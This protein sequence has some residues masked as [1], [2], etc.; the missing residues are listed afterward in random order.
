MEA[1]ELDWTTGTV[2]ANVRSGSASPAAAFVLLHAYAH[3]GAASVR[4]VLEPLLTHAL[5]AAA[6]APDAATRLEWLG[7]VNTAATF[8]DDDRLAA[9]VQE[10]LAD[11]IDGLERA[12]AA[13]YEPGEAPD[14]RSRSTHIV[15]ADALLTAFDLTGR[16]PYPML[17]EELLQASR[18]DGWN[19]SAGAYDGGFVENAIAAAASSRLALLH[20]DPDYTA[21]AVLVRAPRYADDAGRMLAWLRQALPGHE[22]EAAEFGR[23]LIHWLAFT[24]ASEL[25]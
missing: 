8:S 17:A 20:R 1:A 11:A 2:V 12:A 13:I 10:R 19:E 16:L 25:R 6:T 9:T 23:A 18:R 3:A 24:R 4:E 15:C 14:P 7:I 21:R 22:R 5:A